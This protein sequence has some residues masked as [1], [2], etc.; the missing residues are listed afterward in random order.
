MSIVELLELVLL[1]AVIVT[2][3]SAFMAAVFYLFGKGT[4]N[5]ETE[6]DNRYSGPDSQTD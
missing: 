3:F 6:K 5:D 2:L 1:A 4:S